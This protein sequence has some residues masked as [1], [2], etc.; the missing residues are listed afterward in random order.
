M[1]LKSKS[2][3][4]AIRLLWGR[5]GFLRIYAFAAG[6]GV[7]VLA[8]VGAL[9]LYSL[10]KQPEKSFRLSTA[11]NEV[12][13]AQSGTLTTKGSATPLQKSDNRVGDAARGDEASPQARPVPA[14][15]DTVPHDPVIAIT[16]IMPRKRTSRHG[17]MRV[18]VRI[19]VAPRPNAKKGEVEIRVFFYDVT[20]DNEMRPTDAQVAYQWLTPVRDWTDPA[21]KYLAASYV[22]PRMSRHSAERLRYGGFIVQV[23]FDGQLQDEQSDP[24]SLL[25]ALRSSGQQV[26]SSSAAV[27]N[28]PIV[29]LAGATPNAGESPIVKKEAAVTATTAARI[30]AVAPTE[31]PSHVDSTPGP[32]A[33]PVPGKP[34]FVYSPFDKKF[35]IDVRGVAPGTEV[36]DPNTGK[37]FRVP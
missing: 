37:V 19:G 2:L 27:A 5:M 33:S 36:N 12:R 24:K 25:A 1:Q 11:V 10:R 35:V 28:P 26:P 34:G 18:D 8:A 20:R 29:A 3:L 14:L 32:Y 17:Q 23:Y 13:P 15:G 7:V 6:S 31:R 9:H 4:R 30:T 16:E 22:S 21:T